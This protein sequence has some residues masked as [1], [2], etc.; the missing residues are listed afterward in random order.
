MRKKKNLSR[1][2]RQGN[3]TT[4]CSSTKGQ[5][6]GTKGRREREGYMKE[7]K[8]LCSNASREDREV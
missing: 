6:V 8:K 4:S 7:N 5:E 1:G 3:E 2:S